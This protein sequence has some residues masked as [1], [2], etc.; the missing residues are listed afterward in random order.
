MSG[1][2]WYSV[3][4]HEVKVLVP[5]TLADDVSAW[6]VDM[7]ALSSKSDVS[8]VICEMGDRQQ[9]SMQLRDI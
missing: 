8:T 5:L 7:A 6:I 3:D 1:G 4:V 2:E 9:V